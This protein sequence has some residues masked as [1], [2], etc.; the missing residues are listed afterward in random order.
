MQ[1]SKDIQKLQSAYN[2][3]LVSFKNHNLEGAAKALTNIKALE[4]SFWQNLETYLADAHAE[5]NELSQQY[6]DNDAYLQELKGMLE[7]RGLNPDISENT[8]IIGPLDLVVNIEDRHLLLIMGKKKKRINDL[9]INKVAKLVEQSFKRLNSSFNANAFFR[10]VQTAYKYVNSRVYGV[11][12][13]RFGNAVSLKLLYEVFSIAPGS[14]DYKI[15]NFLWDLGRL[16]FASDSYNGHRL[17][18]GN[19]RNAGTMYIIKTAN[20]DSLKASTLSI[21]KEE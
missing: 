20:G 17:E 16:V 5:L 1:K 15:E 6:Q 18:L 21:H 19:S 7:E 3:M 10:R 11:T 8:L 9:E 2:S 13:T 14:Q 12:E 4:D